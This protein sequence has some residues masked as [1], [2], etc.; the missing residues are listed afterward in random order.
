MNITGKLRNISVGFHLK[1]ANLIE[2]SGYRSRAR[3]QLPGGKMI[4]E[5]GDTASSLMMTKHVQNWPSMPVPIET[6]LPLTNSLKSLVVLYQ[7]V[8]Y[9]T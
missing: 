8:Q 1:V 5:R 3:S 4:E 6:K 9:G 2:H 7:R